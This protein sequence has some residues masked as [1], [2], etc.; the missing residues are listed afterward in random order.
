[1]RLLLQIYD[2]AYDMLEKTWQHSS[3]CGFGTSVHRVDH[4]AA[5][6]DIWTDANYFAAKDFAAKSLVGAPGDLVREI[7]VIQEHFSASLYR[8]GFSRCQR[9]DCPVC[10]PPQ[11]PRTPVELFYSKFDGC[12][13]SPVPFFATFPKKGGHGRPKEPVDFLIGLQN[14]RAGTG[15]LH[16]RSLSGLMKQNL[17]GSLMHGDQHYDGPSQR[18]ACP[19]CVPEVCHGSAAALLRHMRVMHM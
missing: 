6:T 11:P 9:S 1:M 16:Y 3:Y 5:S 19:R 17:P 18:H 15:Q 4:D 8:W 14:G 13:P 7:R 10:P 2:N 12:M